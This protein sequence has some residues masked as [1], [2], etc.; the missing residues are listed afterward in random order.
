M[1]QEHYKTSAIS[2]Y[3]QGVTLIEVLVSMLLMAI[4]GLGA[5]YI[6]GRT[7]V[8]HRDQ[9]LHLHTVNQMRQYLESSAG[10]GCSN[11]VDLDVAGK[12]VTVNCIVQTKDYNVITKDNGDN[13][14]VTPVD[15][16]VIVVSPTVKVVEKTDS[17]THWNVP[18]PVEIAP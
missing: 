3:Q 4:I 18:I 5:A 6:S 13:V 12:K 14:I 1:H 11:N 17:T 7:A 2:K 8:L 10:S 9:N 15:R 16:E